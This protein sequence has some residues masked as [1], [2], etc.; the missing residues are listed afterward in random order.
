[1]SILDDLKKQ[2]ELAK[3]QQDTERESTERRE[4]AFR[5]SA[6]PA[7][8][9]ALNYLRELVDTLNMAEPDVRS[10]YEV[11]GCG[12]LKGL[13]Q[14]DYRL[15]VDD[16]EAIGSLKLGFL[17]SDG[18]TQVCLVE[19]NRVSWQKNYLWRHGLTFTYRERMHRT[20][21]VGEFNLVRKVPVSF[22]FTVDQDTAAIQLTVTNLDSLGEKHYRLTPESITNTFLEELAKAVVRKPHRLD[23]LTGFRVDDETRRRLKERLEKEAGERERELAAKG[24]AARRADAPPEA[25]TR[26]G[27]GES[28]RAA[29]LF[30]S[31]FRK[32]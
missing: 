2:A 30:K 13:P 14:S 7:M 15:S 17:C 11:E 21:S 29:G 8:L 22:S 19:A 3:A 24:L 28:K 31:L 12:R 18:N 32:K 1:M 5:R 10:S 27:A 25:E 4:A 6:Q 20:G 16:A 9:T 23:E 26:D